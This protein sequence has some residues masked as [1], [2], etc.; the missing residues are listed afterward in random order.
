MHINSTIDF[1]GRSLHCCNIP[2]SLCSYV[3][4]LLSPF[5]FRHLLFQKKLFPSRCM[6][7]IATL[8]D[9]STFLFLL[10]VLRPHQTELIHCCCMDFESTKR[11]D[12]L[13]VI[14]GFVIQWA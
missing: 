4:E 11:G 1:F 2:S 14:D 6:T 7:E 3:F 13:I 10:P 12:W 9:T 5:P 8:R